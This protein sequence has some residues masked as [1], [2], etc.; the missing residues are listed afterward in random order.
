MLKS[1]RHSIVASLVVGAIAIT[2]STQ[3]MAY[4]CMAQFERAQELV[5]QAE[6]LVKEDT[7][8]R[9]LA[10]IAE[11]RGI[12]QAGLISHKRASEK[13]TGETGKFMHSDSVRKGK[14]AQDLAKQAIFLLSGEIL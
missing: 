11:A 7:D 12:A 3:S 10:M 5:S 14:W 6:K 2:A 13:H 9:I 1:I 8:S 4:S